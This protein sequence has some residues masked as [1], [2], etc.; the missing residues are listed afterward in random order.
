MAKANVIKAN[1]YIPVSAAPFMVPLPLHLELYY[2]NILLCVYTV[3]ETGVVD[4]TYNINTDI[5]ILT[6]VHRKLKAEDIYFLIRSRIFP[7]N[8]YIAPYELQRLGLSSYEPYEI[9]MKTHG[10]M[11]N[12]CY[13]LK[14]AEE[15]ITQSK[16]QNCKRSIFYNLSD[17]LFINIQPFFLTVKND[18]PGQKIIYIFRNCCNSITT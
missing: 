5:P 6:P 8:P 1:S 2:S 16:P 14:S 12:D 3:S 18:L 7:D 17:L 10:I 9:L 11:Q 13:W 15:Q 4:F